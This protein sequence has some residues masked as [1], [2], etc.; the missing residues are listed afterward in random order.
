MEK[1]VVAGREEP[2]RSVVQPRRSLLW[3][4]LLWLLPV[5]LNHHRKAGLGQ[6]P[7]AE[8]IASV[9]TFSDS[10]ALC[11]LFLKVALGG[12]GEERR[13]SGTEAEAR[14]G[15]LHVISSTYQCCIY[16]SHR[17]LPS[18]YLQ[19]LVTIIDQIRSTQAR[20]DIK[21]EIARSIE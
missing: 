10:L 20:L 12:G 21:D 5:G 8:R 19:S 6:I 1:S 11:L 15:S 2:L 13:P 18:H 7:A 3:L 14:L 9:R 16:S 4:I 17:W